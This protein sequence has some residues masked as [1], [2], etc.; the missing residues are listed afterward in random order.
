[1][2]KLMICLLL[3]IVQHAAAGPYKLSTCE[4]TS[5]T[6]SDEQA[7]S[8]KQSLKFIDH[9][10]AKKNGYPHLC[11]TPA[12]MDNNTVQFACDLLLDEKATVSIQ[13]RKTPSGKGVLGPQL[14]IAAGKIACSGE[15]LGS[16]SPGEWVHLEL[17][18][19]LADGN[20][21]VWAK[22]SP[23][24]KAQQKKMAFKDP[25]FSSCTWVGIISSGNTDSTFY[26]DNLVLKPVE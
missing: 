18:L 7:A 11:L 16:Y 5:I 1:M 13:F 15:S 14:K 6:V 23:D 17:E 2:K 9:P 3:S 20:Y 22:S 10:E 21:T 19:R 24:S 8:G 26:L 12:F 4:K 25:A